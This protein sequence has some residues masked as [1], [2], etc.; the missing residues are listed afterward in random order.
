M[1]SEKEP[2]KTEISNPVTRDIAREFNAIV[3]SVDEQS[4]FIHDR[5]FRFAFAKPE[6]MAELLKLFSRRNESLKE[7]LNTIDLTT[8]RGAQEN[9]SSDKH[10]GSLKRILRM[11]GLLGSM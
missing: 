10:T 2:N 3:D 5:D 8:L 6:R 4:E 9:F 7:F 1:T 11:A